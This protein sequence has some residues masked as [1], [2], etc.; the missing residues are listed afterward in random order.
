MKEIKEFLANKDN[1]FITLFLSSYQ[2]LLIKTF[3]EFKK[4]N[5]ETYEYEYLFLDN[6]VYE[7]FADNHKL[8]KYKYEN[9]SFDLYNTFITNLEMETI[10]QYINYLI[11]SD[12]LNSNINNFFNHK[13]KFNS[14]FSKKINVSNKE[15][16]AWVVEDLEFTKRIIPKT[17]RKISKKMYKFLCFYEYTA[18]YKVLKKFEKE[19]WT[20]EEIINYWIKIISKLVKRFVNKISLKKYFKNNKTLK[21][22]WACRLMWVIYWNWIYL[23]HPESSYELE[24]Y[25]DNRKK[26]FWRNGILALWVIS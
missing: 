23:L 1:A 18:K 8:S 12:E 16:L 15:T 2:N 22:F 9:F 10:D 6:L 21:W 14:E 26:Y 25:Y 13:F 17:D 19:N 3:N 24:M 4:I 20:S 5:D 11:Y 7:F